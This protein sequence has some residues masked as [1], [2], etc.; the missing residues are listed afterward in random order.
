M[1]GRYT[2]DELK[3][4]DDYAFELHDSMHSDLKGITFKMEAALP[5]KDTPKVF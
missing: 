3:E 5:V 4:C 1:R 2:K